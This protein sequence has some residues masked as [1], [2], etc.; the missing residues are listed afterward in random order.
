[1]SVTSVRA[2]LAGAAIAAAVGVRAEERAA[3]YVRFARGNA[4][5]YGILEGET[6]KELKGDLFQQPKPT[7]KRFKLSEV[8]LLVPV[9]PQKV[10]GVAGNYVQ[11][12][13][14]PRTEP[15]PHPRW[16]AKLPTSLGLPEAD[17]EI[18]ADAANLDW[19]GE[20]V[21][22]IGKKARH[23]SVD[24]AA[25]CIFGVA[26]GNDVSE[27]TW[28]GER[29]GDEEPARLISKGTDTW[30]PIGRSIVTGVDYNDLGIEIRLNGELA[31]KGRTR[32]MLNSPAQ[33]VSYL[34]RYMTLLPGD[35]IFT[36]TVPR[37]PGT[38][39]ALKA[40]DVVE[41]EI[42]KVGKIRNRVVPMKA[43]AR[44]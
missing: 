18:P 25:S 7:G 44:D 2:I 20:L 29:K 12:G 19:E 36:G 30:A 31:G 26:V 23:V 40:G 27:N 42:E 14:T 39:D 41:V 28:Y 13:Q 43:P 8:K 21:L 38:P 9:E 32:N 6:V 16:F 34:S 37:V 33:L 15:R 10:L 17:I 11:L 1:M 22:V 5:S 3:H 35:L 24:E 4:V